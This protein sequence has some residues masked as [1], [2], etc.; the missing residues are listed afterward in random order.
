MFRSRRAK[1]SRDASVSTS[2]EAPAVRIISSTPR[3]GRRRPTV[4]VPDVVPRRRAA[5]PGRKPPPSN[6]SS[7]LGRRAATTDADDDDEHADAILKMGKR[8]KTAIPLAAAVQLHASE[9]C[10]DP[11][12]SMDAI[13]NRKRASLPTCTLSA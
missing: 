12:C 11:A 3:E 10:V 13:R 6:N 9:S 7:V 5:Q 1:R 4:A 8:G 2:P